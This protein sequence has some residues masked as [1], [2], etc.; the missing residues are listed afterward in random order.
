M[1]LN[2]VW[3]QAAR[4]DLK[5][6]IQYIAERSPAAARMIKALIG[7][8]PESAAELLIFIVLAAFSELAKSSFTLISS[9]CMQ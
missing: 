4:L 1:T 7:A 5:E 9:L 3:T 8:A 6:I 2:V